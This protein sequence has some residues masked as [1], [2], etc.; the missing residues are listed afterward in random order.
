MQAL[1]EELSQQLQNIRAD[2]KQAITVANSSLRADLGAAAQAR[3]QEDATQ[4][5]AQ[6]KS[7][8]GLKPFCC[9]FK[10]HTAGRYVCKLATWRQAAQPQCFA[11]VRQV[12]SQTAKHSCKGLWSAHTWPVALQSGVHGHP[13]MEPVGHGLVV[14]AT[15][16]IKQLR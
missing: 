15:N 6:L 8:Q 12:G 14:T 2:V 5:K 13:L 9:A 16:T 11:F 10:T 4:L 1:D 7:E 3:Q